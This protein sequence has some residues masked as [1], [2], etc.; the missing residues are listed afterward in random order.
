MLFPAL[1]NPPDFKKSGGFANM[2]EKTNCLSD[3]VACFSQ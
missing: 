3:I 2:Y 1:K